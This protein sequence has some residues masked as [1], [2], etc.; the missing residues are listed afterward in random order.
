M[1][2]GLA[3]SADSALDSGMHVLEM[4]VSMYW[5]NRLFY[6]F[7]YTLF[8]VLLISWFVTHSAMLIRNVSLYKVVN[9]KLLYCA[10][11]MLSYALSV[12]FWYNEMF[13]TTLIYWMILSV[14]WTFGLLKA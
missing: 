12:L 3:S 14:P 10:E 11:V 2:D 1:D 13:D 5:F 7:P 8:N 4:D 6:T 9:T